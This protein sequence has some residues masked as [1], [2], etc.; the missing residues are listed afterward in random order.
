[1]DGLGEMPRLSTQ[2]EAV[3]S[4]RTTRQTLEIQKASLQKRLNSV[5]KA[6]ALLDKHPEIG[7]F[8]DAMQ[9]V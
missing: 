1:M 8:M 3:P 7:E 4:N 9:N 6:L 2:L 5:E